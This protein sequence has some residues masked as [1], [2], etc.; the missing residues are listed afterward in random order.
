MKDHEA[1]SPY[2]RLAYV[3]SR[4]SSRAVRPARQRAR[5]FATNVTAALATVNSKHGRSL[6]SGPR[7]TGNSA[8]ALTGL[9]VGERPSGDSAGRAERDGPCWVRICATWEVQRRARTR[10]WWSGIHRERDHRAS[11]GVGARRGRRG[12]P[13]A[14][15]SGRRAGGRPVHPGRLADTAALRRVFATHR[16]DA[17]L[18]LAALA[19]VGESMAQPGL[20]F[21]NNFTGGLSL[22]DAMT[23]SGVSKIVFS[24][25]CAVYGEPTR[26]PARGVR[27]ARIRP[28]PTVRAS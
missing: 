1:S 8:V 21:R 24:S 15:V 7:A 19:L 27:P 4:S 6:V 2:P 16:V 5:R 3:H 18:H 22:L 26:G 11:A 17:V 28:I 9:S 10:G 20:Y 25:T 13:L 23:E 14:R 12:Q